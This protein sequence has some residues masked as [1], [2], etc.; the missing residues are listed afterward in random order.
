MLDGYR[1]LLHCSLAGAAILFLARVLV[2]FLKVF[3]FFA[4]YRPLWDRFG[5]IPYLG[6]FVLC[7][8]LSVVTSAVWNIFY[9]LDRA[10][11]STVAL[12]GDSLMQLMQKAVNEERMISITFDSRKWYA[13][14]LIKAP[15]LR[16]SEQYFS[17]LPVLSGYRDKDTLVARRSIRYDELYE[18][19]HEDGAT[20][21]DDFVITL[22]IASVRTANL[23]DPDVYEDHFA[24]NEDAAQT[25]I[26][27]G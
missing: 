1:L 4:K 12:N 11:E 16:P 13:G 14:Y 19:F 21:V 10:R 3:P 20:S 18:K 27:T 22:P 7:I 8:P 26:I 25:L 5:E 2:C 24:E 17:L 9:K 6:T 15:D 23:F